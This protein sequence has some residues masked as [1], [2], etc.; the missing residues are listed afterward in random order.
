MPN[1]GVR[2]CRQWMHQLKIKKRTVLN[3]FVCF[4]THA[5]GK[6]ELALP[7]NFD[8]TIYGFLSAFQKKRTTDQLWETQKRCVMAATE[9][10]SHFL[11]NISWD[12]CLH[13][14]CSIDFM[15]VEDPQSCILL[16]ATV[17][18]F[19]V[20]SRYNGHLQE[21]ALWGES[22]LY[23]GAWECSSMIG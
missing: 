8:I 12:F 6:M 21:V 4:G 2:V 5:N 3:V 14:S 15:N 22:W 16:V 20:N 9:L 19:T 17:R 23:L 10:L 18:P 13:V 7:N 1:I 11:A